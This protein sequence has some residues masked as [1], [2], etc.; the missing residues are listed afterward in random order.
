MDKVVD[1]LT[2][3][4]T[5]YSIL[6]H[7]TIKDIVFDVKE[8]VALEGNSGPYLQYT[9]ARAL[10]ILEKAGI[11]TKELVGFD[12]T[13]LNHPKEI[14]ILKHFLKFPEIVEQAER[15]YSPNFICDYLFELAQNFNNFY[16]HL[17]VLKAETKDL[18]KARLDLVKALA[19]VLK[20][21]LYL[22]GISA[23]EKM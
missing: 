10:S 3:G 14:I 21:G 8:S 13:N 18:K 6:K 20:N 11:K 5:K 22:L 19:Q 12:G 17:P 4:A 9:H 2:I 15:K 23:P 7:T 1:I 16:E